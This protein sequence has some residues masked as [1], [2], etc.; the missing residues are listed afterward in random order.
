MTGPGPFFARHGQAAAA[1]SARPRHVG[2][3]LMRQTPVLAV[4]GVPPGLVAAAE[5]EAALAAALLLPA[6]G[7]A[8]LGAWSRRWPLD[9]DLRRI[10]A[11]VT[12]A[13]VF[14]SGALLT[15]PGF[16]VLG[17]PPLDALFEGVSAITTTGLSV[18]AATADWPTAGH[19]L[20]AWVQWCG[21]V[22]M[23]VA[24]VALLM[25]AGRAARMMGEAGGSESGGSE[26]GYLASTRAT[27]RVILAGY[28]VLTGVGILGALIL[29]PGW[30]GP[31]VALAAV[32]TGGF[33]PRPDSL[34]S[35]TLP[36]RVFV[37]TLCVAGA[38]SLVFYAEARRR[39]LRAALARGTVP[40]TLALIGGGAALYALAHVLTGQDPDRLVDG[41]LNQVSAQTTAG[42]SS[43]PVLSSG[44]PVLLLLGAMILGG[45][46]GSTTGGIKTGRVVTI[47]RMIGLVFLRLR[48]PDRAVTHLK[49]GGQRA[50]GGQVIYA[51]ALLAIY[52]I[53]LLLL[54][55]AFLAGDHPPLHALFDAASALSGVGLSTGVIGPD[56]AAPLKVATILGMLLGRLEFFALIALVLPSTWLPRR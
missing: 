56:L 28:A 22:V 17:L 25:G 54:W 5:G 32:S 38:V 24:G 34:A 2:R 43:A 14:A 26:V 16:L 3:A 46:V 10:E 1:V 12:L 27:A 29:L 44:P 40:A 37:M 21:G 20:R 47:V 39:G 48:M 30:D 9:D 50:E 13:L 35:Y 11:V 42:F 7:C 23:A 31:L 53:S 4:V 45:D 18:A 33:T 8:G 51:T 19:V 41:I 15:V 6:L 49:I 36:A 55:L 52:L